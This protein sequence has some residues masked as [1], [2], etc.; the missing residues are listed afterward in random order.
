M[1]TNK[2]Y[3]PDTPVLMAHGVADE[4]GPY[5]AAHKTYE[6]WCKNGGEVEFL[7]YEN[8][9]AGQVGMDLRDE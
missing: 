7:S 1:G 2:E 5:E 9:L 8:A 6:A 4:I 3:T